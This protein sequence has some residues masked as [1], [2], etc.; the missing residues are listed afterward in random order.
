[1]SFSPVAFRVL[2]VDDHPVVRQVWSN[3]GGG[4]DIVIVGQRNGHEAI[5][6]FQHQRPDV[7]LMDGGR[8]RWKVFRR[9]RL[10]CS[11]F[12][13]RIIAVGSRMMKDVKRFI[14]GCSRAKVYWRISGARGTI[15]RNS[16][17]EHV[18][19]QYIPPTWLPSLVQR[20]PVQNW[21]I[22]PE[23]LPVGRTG[24]YKSGN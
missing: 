14:E 21:V 15:D 19:Q 4:P 5:A 7:T 10:V 11:E 6:V 18:G 16:C 17:R 12:P 20:W 23:V 24:N 8:L 9:L 22:E 1:M 2:V 13:V 3:V